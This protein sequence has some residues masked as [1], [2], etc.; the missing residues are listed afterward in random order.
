LK[1]YVDDR[2]RV[3]AFSILGATMV[4]GWAGAY[5]AERFQKSR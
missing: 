4:A 5:F 3:V 1:A 2:S